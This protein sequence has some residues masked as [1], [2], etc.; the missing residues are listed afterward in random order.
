MDNRI[1]T[2][3][4]M[5]FNAHPALNTQFYDGWF[6]RFAD[7]FSK[8]ANSVNMLYPSTVD[9]EKKIDECERR[10]VNQKLASVFKIIEGEHSKIDLILEKRGY[11]I[12]TPSDLKFL[13]LAE[14]SFSE[15]ECVCFD[16]PEEVWIDSWAT[17]EKYSEPSRKTAVKILNNI[18]NKTIYISLIENGVC[19]AC[20]SSVMENGYAIIGNVV[21]DEDFRGK[22]Y[23]RKLCET[24]LSKLKKE[25]VHTAYL[26]VVQ[27]N[28]PAVK[29]YDGLGFK[30]LYSYWY[31]VKEML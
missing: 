23:S 27:T 13:D 8:R 18:Q 21:V 9:V 15:Y 26:Q 11:E 22:G 28:T 16:K 5:S 20:A 29:L 4:E 10:Y 25:G 24:L 17:F 1:R 6:L 12:A 2:Y 19:V 3:E 14:K 7:G 31:R 30:K